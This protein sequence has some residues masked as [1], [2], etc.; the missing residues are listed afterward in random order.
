[1]KRHKVD[2]VTYDEIK[3][4][5]KMLL[6]LGMTERDYAAKFHYLT[7]ADIVV[8]QRE[9]ISSLQSAKKGKKHASGE[10]GIT[11]KKCP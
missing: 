1:M 7:G 10:S 3:N 2:S 6:S 9:E 5:F 8:K 11:I 4:N